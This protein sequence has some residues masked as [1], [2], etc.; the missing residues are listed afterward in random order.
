MP[1]LYLDIDVSMLSHEFMGEKFS[2]YLWFAGIVLGT[3]LLK[4]PLAA[5]VMRVSSRIAVKYSYVRHKE[6]VGSM[7]LKPLQRLLLVIL[8]FAATDQLSVLLERVSFHRSLVATKKRISFSLGDITDH[9]FLFLFILTLTQV[10]V[11]FID[12]LYYVRMARAAEDKNQ[13]TIQMLPLMKEMSKLLVWTMAVFA[14]LGTVFHVNIPALIAGLGIGGVAIALA[15]KE[16]VENFF[17]AFTILSDK[18]FQSGDKIKIGDV[19]GVV[20]RIGFRSTRLR[21]SDGSAYVIPNQNL[22]SQNLVN[23]TMRESW[24]VKV[25]A[26]IRYG[27]SH[28]DLEKMMQELKVQIPTFPPATLPVEA[29]VESFDK[30]TFLLVVTYSLPFPF[31]AHETIYVIKQRINT[32]IFE[33]ISKYAIVGSHA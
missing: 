14:V 8:F 9:I 4:R 31:P 10:I 5:L 16:T 29:Y 27:V 22:V 12:F 28:T 15:G 7:L 32:K 23:L 11:R 33:L 13:S 25:V 30:E 17:A 20:E 24:V 3:L 19:E 18:P 26:N 6:V 21:N 2:N 1:Y